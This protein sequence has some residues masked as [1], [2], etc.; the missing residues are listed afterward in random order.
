MHI[1]ILGA[2]G[3]T[4]H[5]TTTTAL[6]K[7]HTVTALV[8]K[9]SSLTP[10]PGLTIVEGTPLNQ[11]DI[12]RA[13]TSGPKPDACIVTLAA[14]RETDSPFSKPM[15]PPF[16]MRDSVRNLMVVMRSHA[17]PEE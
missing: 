15:A 7:N 2:S 14:P 12:D 11:P 5:L 3:R 1:L 8:R 16:F 6:A 4:G 13:F 9:S 10:T 17:F